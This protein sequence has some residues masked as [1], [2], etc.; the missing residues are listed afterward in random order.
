MNGVPGIPNV[1]VGT[2]LAAVTAL[3]AP[4]GPITPAMFPLPNF[5]LG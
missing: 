5:L 1:T 3:L 2:K 4:S